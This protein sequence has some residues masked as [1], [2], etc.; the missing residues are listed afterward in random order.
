VPRI[1][2]HAVVAGGQAVAALVN[3]PLALMAILAERTQRPE[4]E[5]VV[6]AAM[7]WMMISDRRR[8]RAA[9]LEAESAERLEAK[10]MLGARPPGLQVIPV[11]PRHCLG[12]C[13]VARVHV[14]PAHAARWGKT[15]TIAWP[16]PNLV[17]MTRS[18]TIKLAH[19][20]F[21][22]TLDR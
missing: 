9:S 7:S 8:R 12:G 20:C 1:R 17:T 16:G 4:H 6:V 15:P 11:P 3:G 2:R 13:E 14:E 10:L 22:R 19:V 21:Q 18:Q 5:L